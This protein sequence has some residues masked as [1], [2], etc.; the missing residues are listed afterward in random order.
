MKTVIAHDEMDCADAAIGAGV[1]SRY[2]LRIE[3]PAVQPPLNDSILGGGRTS[4]PEQEVVPVAWVKSGPRDPYRAW[5]YR[6]PADD[7]HC[8]SHG[9][10]DVT[11]CP[12]KICKLPWRSRSAVVV[13]PTYKPVP[14]PGGCA[15]P[16]RKAR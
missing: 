11:S 6:K 16:L 7:A 14:L 3:T 9:P 15:E 1:E 2:I 8:D 12:T 5:F 13:V 4:P 10:L